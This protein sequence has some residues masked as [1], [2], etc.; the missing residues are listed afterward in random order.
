MSFWW[1][2]ISHRFRKN[3]LIFLVA[4]KLRNEDT[5]KDQVTSLK[6]ISP[7]N[8]GYIWQAMT[9][10]ASMIKLLDIEDIS[11]ADHRYLDAPAEAYC[12]ANS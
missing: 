4:V 2:G 1:R 10:S 5:Q 9:S 7:E 6:T 3:G 12:D 11:Q 8:A